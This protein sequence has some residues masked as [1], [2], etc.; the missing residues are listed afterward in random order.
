ML[1]GVSSEQ[2]TSP[3]V[4]IL[5]GGFG[6]ATAIDVTS[7]TVSLADRLRQPTACPVQM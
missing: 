4:V 7:R 3:H 1:I 5:G 6:E 2:E